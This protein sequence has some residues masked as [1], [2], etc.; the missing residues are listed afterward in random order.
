MGLFFYL[1]SMKENVS[2]IVK[3]SAINLYHFKNLDFEDEQKFKTG[4]I[5]T[6][7]EIWKDFDNSPSYYGV[8]FNNQK[9]YLEASTSIDY[10]VEEVKAK[11]QQKAQTT[12]QKKTPNFLNRV[13]L[14]FWLAF[15][16]FFRT[17]LW[18]FENIFAF[19]FEAVSVI[20]K[21]GLNALRRYPLFLLIV[22][23]IAILL[24]IPSGSKK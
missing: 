6:V 24:L 19:V 8:M 18:L 21:A 9:R 13:L 1:Y 16:G 20:L 23:V 5:F 4:D 15:L 7:V 14:S 17:L 22:I 11:P 3:P 2:Y 12:S 10:D